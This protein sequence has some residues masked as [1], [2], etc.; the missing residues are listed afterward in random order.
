[1]KVPLG[2][3]DIKAEEEEKTPEKSEKA[4]TKRNK[5]SEYVEQFFEIE[6][7]QEL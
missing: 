3:Y 2:I 1:M 5:V 4:G 6:S 7:N